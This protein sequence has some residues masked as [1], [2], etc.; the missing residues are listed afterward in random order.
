[1]RDPD[2]L[3]R[4]AVRRHGV[5]TWNHIRDAGLS[6]SYRNRQLEGGL[7]IAL[8]DNV[9]IAAST[10]VTWHARLRAA[11][12]A[13][14]PEAA[15]SHRAATEVWNTDPPARGLVEVSTS[16]RQSPELEGVIVHRSTDL[17]PSWVTIRDGIPVTNP[18]RTII[19]CGAVC[20]PVALDRIYVAA[21]GS[22]LVTHLGVTNALDALARRGRNGVRLV[23]GVLAAHIDEPVPAGFLEGRWRA[24][25]RKFALPASIP[26]YDVIVDGLWL[27]RVDA[28]IPHLRQAWEVVGYAKHGPYK[29]WEG[30]HER[31]QRLRE[32]DWDVEEFT[33][34]Q[35]MFD[36]RTVARRARAAVL[37]R[38]RLLGTFSAA[39]RR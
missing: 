28:A 14:G 13:I 23:R 2:R 26:E 36:E 3:D 25:E 15:V 19:D 12:D 31:R 34:K 7:W 4:I 9:Y 24:L 32:H 5:F 39:E 16:R 18:L 30:D 33:Y 35:V 37:R 6:A 11:C 27:G 1:M 20:G 17:D 38:Q 29:Y 8:H 22:K 21:T 10:P